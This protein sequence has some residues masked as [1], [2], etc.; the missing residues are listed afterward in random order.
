MNDIGR[1][2]VEKALDI[3]H[4]GRQVKGFSVQKKESDNFLLYCGHNNLF[5]Q[6]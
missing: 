4:E 6:Q 3:P 2:F 5:F 1:G